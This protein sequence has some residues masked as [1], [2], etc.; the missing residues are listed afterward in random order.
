MTN[1]FR[2]LFYLYGLMKRAYWPRDRLREYQSKKVRRI[3][4]YAYDY[5]P[6]YHNR[7][8]EEGIKPSEIRTVADLNK[9]PILRKDEIRKKSIHRS[10]TMA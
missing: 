3:V 4:R 1:Y 5:V 6:F 2:A 10:L 8:R 9:L 7:L